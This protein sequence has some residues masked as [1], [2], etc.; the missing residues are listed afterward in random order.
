MTTA[1]P[2]RPSSDL[3]ALSTFRAIASRLMLPAIVLIPVLLNLPFFE[4]PFEGDEGAYGTIA[5]QML[6]GA[7]PYRDLFDHKPPLIYVWYAVSFLLF[8]ENI[9]APRIAA[10]AV[11]SAT[12]L[13]VYFQAKL[14]LTKRQALIAAFLFAM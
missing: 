2:A 10:A 11:W 8:G 13:L 7:L 4:E 3:P 12:T 5:Q 9:I 14:L 1:A 6:H